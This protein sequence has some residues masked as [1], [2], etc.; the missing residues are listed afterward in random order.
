MV[1]AGQVYIHENG[2]EYQVLML[3]NEHASPDKRDEYPLTVV[4][5]G[6]DGRRWS[7]SVEAFLLKR[8][9]V[10]DAL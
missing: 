3:T 5:Q 6:P 4:Y 7:K 10:R 9:L 8:R 2:N 1:S